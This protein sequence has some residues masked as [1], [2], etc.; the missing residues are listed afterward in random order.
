MTNMNV[1]ISADEANILIHVFTS[2][3]S[4]RNLF[5]GVR[6]HCLL[7]NASVRVCVRVCVC[8]LGGQRCHVSRVAA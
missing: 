3:W 5:W 2:K 1:T 7:V 8:V 4:F 6:R